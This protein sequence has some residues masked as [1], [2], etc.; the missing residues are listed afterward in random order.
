MDVDLLKEK[1]VFVTVFASYL[2]LS[3]IEGKTVLGQQSLSAVRLD[4]SGKSPQRE[5]GK[6]FYCFSIPVGKYYL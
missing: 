3:R 6:C 1:S 5:L 4:R 2:R